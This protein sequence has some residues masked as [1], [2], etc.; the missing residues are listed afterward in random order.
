M[1]LCLRLKWSIRWW[2]N[3]FSFS[4]ISII[5]RASNG[6]PSPGAAATPPNRNPPSK[7]S[8][9]RLRATQAKIY[10]LIYGSSRLK[11]A[12]KNWGESPLS[13]DRKNSDAEHKTQFLSETKNTLWCKTSSVT[14]FWGVCGTSVSDCAFVTV[15]ASLKVL[16]KVVQCFRCTRWAKSFLNSLRRQILPRF[17]FPK[18]QSRASCFH[19]SL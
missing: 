2:V 12:G 5:P 10:G 1:T 15:T 9:A 19:W 17:G 6:S 11:D 7:N 4:A 3:V 16:F 14:Q 8:G 18:S 13:S